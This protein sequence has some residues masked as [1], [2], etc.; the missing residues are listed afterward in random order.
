MERQIAARPWHK[1]G[2]KVA[3]RQRFDAQC[4]L[5]GSACTALTM[6]TDMPPETPDMFTTAVRG[7]W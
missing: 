5:R 2:G 4:W 7:T 1:L 3:R 6:E